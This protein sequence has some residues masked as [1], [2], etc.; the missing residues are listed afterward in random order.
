[1]QKKSVVVTGGLGFIGSELVRQL[2]KRSDVGE[3]YIFDN[4]SKHL[5]KSIPENCYPLDLS[6]PANIPFISEF[7][8]AKN[9][10]IVYSLAALIGGIKYFHDHPADILYRNNSITGNTLQAIVESKTDCHFTYISS[11]MVFETVD[12]FPTKES[13]LKSIPASAYGFS[14]LVGEFLC[15]AYLRQY[16]VT[17]T[18]CR[19]FNAYGCNEYPKEVGIAH[20]IPDLI[21]KILDGQGTQDNPLEI[22]GDGNQVRCYTHVSDIA[23]GIISAT[24]HVLHP[25]GA[26][27]AYQGDSNDFNISCAKPHTVNEVAEL[28]WTHI[29]GDKPL[30]RKYLP[31]FE[32]DVQKRIPDTTKA[33][34]ILGWEAQFTLEEELHTIIN[35]VKDNI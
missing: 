28:I 3:I 5:R 7:L 35:W 15:E 16:G 2:E 17:Y 31:S 25:T 12:V 1:M 18:I 22:L 34:K 30:Y 23:H 29:H 6:D 13:D 4:A 11:S 19:P 14:K 9:I 10:S 33:K 21:K 32:Y 8:K 20:V 24:K 26:N 27:L